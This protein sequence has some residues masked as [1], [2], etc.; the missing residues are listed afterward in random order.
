MQVPPDLSERLLL[1]QAT[2]FSYIISAIALL[3][4]CTIALIVLDFTRS[5]SEPVRLIAFLGVSVGYL[6]ILFNAHR[7]LRR[8]TANQQAAKAYIATMARILAILG[9]YWSI[10]LIIVVKQADPGQLNLLYGI[11]AGCLATPVMVAPAICAFAFWLPISIGICVAV[12]TSHEADLFAVL[13]LLSFI[14]LTGFCIFY[15]NRRM[16]ERA[17]GAIRLEENA[18]VIRLL[19][20][21]F[22]ESASDWL[23]ETNAQMT[24]QQVSQR[25]VQVARRPPESFLGTFPS[26]M[27][28]EANL[29]DAPAGSTVDGCNAPSE[30]ARPSGIL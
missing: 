15:L 24:M 12:I 28:G 30:N 5:P 20:R 21:D 1:D 13:D 4:L 16:N 8:P 22:E 29:L 23:W 10:L 18:E 9:S 7:W 19:L 27:L 17:V 25:L 14:G 6:A 26:A 11:M 2:D 3:G